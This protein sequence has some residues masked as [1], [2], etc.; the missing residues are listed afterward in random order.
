VHTEIR[1]SF[2]SGELSLLGIEARYVSWVNRPSYALLS[3]VIQSVGKKLRRK[4]VDTEYRLLRVSKRGDRQYS[5]RILGKFKRLERISKGFTFF[6][7]RGVNV[8]GSALLMTLEYNANECSLASSWL[9]ASRD[10]NVFLSRLRKR[11]GQIFNVRVYESHE[12]GFLHI[13]VLLVFKH[14]FQGYRQRG[15]G[16]IFRVK[17]EDFAFLKGCWNK[18]FSDIQLVNSFQGGLRYLSKY[19]L[20]STCIETANTKGLKTLTLNWVFHKRAFAFSGKKVIREFFAND[21]IFKFLHN[22]SHKLVVSVVSGLVSGY[23]GFVKVFGEWRFS[24][25]VKNDGVKWDNPN[26]SSM[27]ISA[28]KLVLV[29]ESKVNSKFN[30]YRVMS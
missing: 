30:L 2:I 27:D 24:G 4:K 14:V 17:G 7:Y 22:S 19:L 6:D 20:K 9:N 26:S 21:E 3:R 16:F 10:F 8:S 1:D 18:G 13:H 28:E 23:R 25:F 5:R 29:S 11:Y 15:K 12:S